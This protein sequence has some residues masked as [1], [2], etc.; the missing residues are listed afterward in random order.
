MP[1]DSRHTLFD[2]LPDV[3]WEELPGGREARNAAS[4]DAWRYSSTYM[5][6]DDNRLHF[7]HY[8]AHPD[9][10]GEYAFATVIERGGAAALATFS[11]QVDGVDLGDLGPP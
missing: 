1:A 8:R 5:A 7:F 3:V 6:E 4:G 10:S 11:I 2:P 9:Y